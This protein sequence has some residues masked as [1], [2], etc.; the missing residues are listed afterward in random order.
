MPRALKAADGK[1]LDRESRIAAYAVALAAVANL[2]QQN[3]E[4][5][6]DAMKKHRLPRR[7]EA[8]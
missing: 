5:L 8:S 3:I 4:D 7:Q 1:P 2:S 6:I